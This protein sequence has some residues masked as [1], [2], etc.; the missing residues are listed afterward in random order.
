MDRNM[1][2]SIKFMTTPENLKLF[3]WISEQKDPD[4]FIVNILKD[5]FKNNTKN[6]AKDISSKDLEMLLNDDDF[7]NN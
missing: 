5:A 1:T 2:F 6:K 7:W 3:T 4:K